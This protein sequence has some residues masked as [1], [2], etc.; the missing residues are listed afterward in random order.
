MISSGGLKPVTPQLATNRYKIL[1]R[2]LDQLRNE[3][4]PEY[5]SYHPVEENIEAL[6]AARAKAFIHLFM[7]VYFG[8]LD[9]SAREQHVTEGTDDGGIDAYYI[10]V[11]RKVIYFIQSKFRHSEHNFEEKNIELEELLKM[12]IDRILNGEISS[13]SGLPYNS[14]IQQMAEII[15]KIDDIGRYNYRV[16]ILANAK[17]LTRQKLN[18]LTG[19]FRTQLFDYNEC[20]TQLLFPLVSGSFFNADVL[21]LSLNLSNKN[22]AS[23]ISYTALTEHGKCEITVVF[24]P[25]LEIAKAM[26]LY[27]NAILKYNPRSYL[28]FEGQNVNKAIRNSVENLK[29]NEFALFNNG[30]TMLSDETYLN[31]RIGQKDRAQMTLINPQIINGG[32]TA[33]TLSQVYKDYMK[34][35]FEEIF[36]EKEVLIKIIT[37]D[38]APAPNEHNKRALIEAISR[39]TNSQTAVTAADRRSNEP[40]I[41]QLQKKLFERLGILLERKK[42]NS[43]TE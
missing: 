6:N 14:K 24:V 25:T 21:H 5:K 35:S 11:D 30:I 4:P 34:D 7:K 15:R 39:A 3:A 37:F 41:Q 27:R 23:K 20:Y 17:E 12:D 33:Y 40:A 13:E 28:E 1:I 29:T 26:F 19:G 42:A 31:E 43:L 22:A 32:Q 38:H 9:F 18:V 36:G 2:I 16:I 10:D 8:M